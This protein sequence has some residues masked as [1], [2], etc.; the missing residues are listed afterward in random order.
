M[1]VVWGKEVIQ[2]GGW[3]GAIGETWRKMEG[4]KTG[5]VQEDWGG[6]KGEK[7]RGRKVRNVMERGWREERTDGEGRATNGS[8]FQHC[9]LSQKSRSVQLHVP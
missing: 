3:R 9:K 5:R 4:N 7:W 1:E 2:K 8:I 6:W